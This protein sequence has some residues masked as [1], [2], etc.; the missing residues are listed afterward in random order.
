M[1]KE[2][3][4]KKA[5]AGGKA[6]GIA[7]FIHGR[8]GYAAAAEHLALTL[9]KHNTETP[10]HLWAAEGMN[11]DHSLF[12]KVHELPAKAYAQ[13]P[14]TMKLNVHGLL[15]KGD[16]LYLDADTLVVAD[17]RP[18]IERLQ[19][20]DFAIHVQGYGGEDDSIAYTPWATQTTIREVL[21]LG[22]DAVYYGVQS[23]YMWIRK[24]SELAK[25]IFKEAL[26]MPFEQKHLK[27]RWGNDIPD[28]L[29]MSAALTNLGIHPYSEHLM[30]Y[31]SGHSYSGLTAV[32]EAFP[33]LCLYGDNRQ[34]RL[35]R[36]TWMKDYD[37][38]LQN[39]YKSAGRVYAY[40]LDHVMR[41]K[42]VNRP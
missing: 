7:V 14:G 32:A 17:P 5:K 38:Y 39:V 35:V 15:P 24:G 10:L 30:F 3:T 16:W 18:Y 19:Q 4:Q 37:R 6:P 21:K 28:E 12:T 20:H 34:H 9:R 41:D 25:A 27:E 36:P 13:G 26:S 2:A 8:H 31:G 22:P 29:R 11:F 23:S 33:F 1:P 40:K 42:Y